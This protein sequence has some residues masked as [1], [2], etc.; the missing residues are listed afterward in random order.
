KNLQ[1]VVVRALG[2]FRRQPVEARSTPQEFQ[3]LS[4]QVFEWLVHVNVS[5]RFVFHESD[6]RTVVHEG[7]KEGLTLSQSI[8]S[9]FAFGDVAS[10]TLYRGR[11]VAAIYEPGA[12][13]QRNSMAVFG[14]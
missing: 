4:K 3:F 2:R 13:F 12:D 1:I 6:R 5:T 14:D 7:V 9:A 11:L 10:N 8:L